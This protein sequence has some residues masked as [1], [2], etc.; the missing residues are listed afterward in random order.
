MVMDTKTEK[1]YENTD[2]YL[3]TGCPCAGLGEIWKQM[4]KCWPC[5][6]FDRVMNEYSQFLQKI[7]EQ[8]ATRAR[9]L[10]ATGNGKSHLL[11]SR[12]KPRSEVQFKAPINYAEPPRANR[13]GWC[14]GK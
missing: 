4:K 12:E 2:S 9:V 5:S 13:T 8:T 1:R 6:S 10:T 3:G 7:S 14:G 11:C